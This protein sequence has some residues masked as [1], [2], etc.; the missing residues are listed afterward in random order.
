MT[1]RA[2]LGLLLANWLPA[3]AETFYV[4]PDGTGDYPN[5]QA[6]V[7]AADDGDVIVLADGVFRG[8]GNWDVWVLDKSVTIESE[9][10]DPAST[11]M[12]CEDGANQHRAFFLGGGVQPVVVHGIGMLH[13]HA[14]VAIP[15]GGAVN[16]SECDVVFYKCLFAGN[17]ATY[18]GRHLRTVVSTPDYML[19]LLQQ[20]GDMGRRR[21]SPGFG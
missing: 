17:R 1:A 9:S 11:A 8:E 6:A 2:A 7:D 20:R 4:R 5:I 16:V 14:S 19:H 18:E 15:A 3:S 10:G 21:L 13:G 12:D